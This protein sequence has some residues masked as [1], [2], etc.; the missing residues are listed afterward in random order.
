MKLFFLEDR[1][2]DIIW[3]LFEDLNVYYSIAKSTGA[4]KDEGRNTMQLQQTDADLRLAANCWPSHSF[5]DHNPVNNH[6]EDG[7]I[8]SYLCAYK[9]MTLFFFVLICPIM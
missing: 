7:A 9:L 6:K 3:L 1:S 4:V 8:T 5:V 2:F